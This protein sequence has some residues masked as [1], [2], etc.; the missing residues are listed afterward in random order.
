MDIEYGSNIQETEYQLAQFYSGQNI[1]IILFLTAWC[2]DPENIEQMRDKDPEKFCFDW[3]TRSLTPMISRNY[4]NPA[5][6]LPRYEREWV[7]STASMI[8]T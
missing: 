4:I 2:W 8:G 6:V 5:H 7:F 3:W 1:D